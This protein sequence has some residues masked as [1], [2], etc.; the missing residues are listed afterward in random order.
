MIEMSVN[1][2]TPG[3]KRSV[4]SKMANSMLPKSCLSFLENFQGPTDDLV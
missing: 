4:F 3:Q 2:K 1:K